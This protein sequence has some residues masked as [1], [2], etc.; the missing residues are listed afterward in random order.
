[1]LEL[2]NRARA[3]PAAEAQRLLAIAETDPLIHSLTASEDLSQ[4]VQVLSS[5][6]PEPPL[7]FSPDLIQ[8]AR[9][10][11]AAMLA[12]NTQFHSPLGSNPS[13]YGENIYAYSSVLASPDPT[14][15][16]N[17]FDEAFFLDW[18]NPDFGHLKNLMWPGPAEDPSNGINEIGIGLMTDAYPTNPPAPNSA[19]PSYNV[20]PDLITQEF[21]SSGGNAFLTGVVFLDSSNTGFYAPG[22]G[23]GGTGIQAVGLQ[24]QGTFQTV[25]W[26]S[27]GY[28]LPLPP[29]TYDVTATG[30]VLLSPQTTV[31]TIGADNVEWDVRTVPP[32]A[33]PAPASTNPT[34]TPTPTVGTAPTSSPVPITAPSSTTPPPKAHTT[35]TVHAKVSSSYLARL[36]YLAEHAHVKAKLSVHTVRR[37]TR[38]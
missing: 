4:F 23:Y 6:G 34:P 17:F 22:E 31:V 16:I 11:D 7:A 38:G 5:Y 27:G 1:M 15:A 8:M 12:A 2:I 9:T 24:G 25:T 33:T 14:A 37:P 36:I 10:H 3:N 21:G 18:G 13:S 30:G 35:S 19:Y 28:S 20:G 26:D 29:G 32:P